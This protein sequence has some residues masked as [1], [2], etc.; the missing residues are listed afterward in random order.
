MPPASRLSPITFY[1]NEQHE[2][3]R[4]EREGGG[5][6][7]QYHGI[8]WAGKGQQIKETLESVRSAITASHDPLRDLH[9][10]LL[11]KP[12]SSVQKKSTN[13]RLA[14]DGI[15]TEKIRFDES[16]SRVF[17]RLGMDLVEVTPDGDAVVHI[18]PERIKQL[19]ATTQRLAE[20]GAREQA[21]WASVDGFGVIPPELRLDAGWIRS[22][23]P[24][25]AA[26]A[27]VEFQPL[28]GRV[29]VEALLSSISGL[30]RHDRKE[31]ITGIGADFSGRYWARGKI[32]PETLNIIGLCAG[33]CGE[34]RIC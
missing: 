32:T 16:D 27:V 8:D 28:L 12:V 20:V 14:P 25:S 29:E 19:V 22:L 30:F 13:K 18:E 23:R 5:R 7:P 1:L 33:M 26:E 11:A 3:S 34:G 15:L 6:F 17:R 4:G 9:Y 31:G 21:R 24:H 2:L 10:F